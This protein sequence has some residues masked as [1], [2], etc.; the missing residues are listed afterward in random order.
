SY[1]LWCRPHLPGPSPDGGNMVKAEDQA[2]AFLA[3]LGE[4]VRNMRALRGMSRRVLSK[5]SGLSARYIAQMESGKGN[6][7]IMLLRQ[8]ANAMGVKLEDLIPST[9]ST[10]DWPVIRDLLRGASKEQ[11]AHVKAVL[12]ERRGS[13]WARNM[14]RVSLIGLRGAGKSTLGRI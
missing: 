1:R 6:V 10:P 12:S 9:D 7:S 13:T 8:L 14:Q 3:E 4:R 2:D 5:A 11:I